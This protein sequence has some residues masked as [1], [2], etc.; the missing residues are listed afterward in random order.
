MV[1]GMK[2]L[3]RSPHDGLFKSIFKNARN[4]RDFQVPAFPRNEGNSA[5]PGRGEERGRGFQYK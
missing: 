1:K 2:K 5:E 4:A 3:E